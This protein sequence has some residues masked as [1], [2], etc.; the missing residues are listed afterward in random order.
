[1]DNLK[2]E[3]LQVLKITLPIALGYITIGFTF[4]VMAIKIGLSPL[5]SLLMSIIVYAGSAQLIAVS[6]FAQKVSPLVIIITTFI[7]NLRH[8]LMSLAL[9]PYLKKWPKKLL[10]FFFFELTDETFS[11]HYLNFSKNNNSI[12]KSILINIISH[13]SWI[14]GTFLGIIFGN[15]ITDISKFGLDFS[16]VGMFAVL[17]AWQ[18]NKPIHILVVLISSMFTLFFN[19]IN[20]NNLS[21]ILSS[22]LA[23][24]IG[25]G[26]SKWKNK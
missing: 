16:L 4:G 12:Y 21:V 1:M 14:T 22:I 10:P 24:T 26:I 23:A 7:V 11:L 3:T 25:L 17:I 15:L 9:T 8:L 19:F 20:L 6:L 13:L 18:I 2:Q 5:A